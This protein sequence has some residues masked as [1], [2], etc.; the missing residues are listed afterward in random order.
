MGSIL[1]VVS[2][3]SLQLRAR[4]VKAYEPMRVL[5]FPAQLTVERLDER[6]VGR[7]PRPREIERHDMRIGPE[8][9]VARDE[10]TALVNAYALWIT[11]GG[12]TRA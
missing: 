3:P 11:T 6:I 9:Q 8:I 7:L 4:I 1:V 12:T 5:A 10:F 2:A